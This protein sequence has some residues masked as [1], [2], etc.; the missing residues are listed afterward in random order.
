M[1]LSVKELESKKVRF[2]ETFT[3]GMIDYLDS[4]LR[5]IS[6][7]KTE[8]IAEL[9]EDTVG[10]VRVEG[11]LAVSLEF[12]CDRCL[13]PRLVPVDSAF[14]LFYRPAPSLQSKNPSEEVELDEGEIELAF[15]EGDGLELEEILR[16]H[17]L[18]LMPMQ[19]ICRDGCRG[20]CSVCGRNLN[21]ASCGCQVKP[22]DDRWAALKNL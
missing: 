15:Y 18:L 22:A 5:Q 10:D 9:L 1:F 16:E 2:D 12:D 8:G 3:P 11:R 19:R 14:D 20:L 13:D 17:I 21:H 4:G 6:P 7:L